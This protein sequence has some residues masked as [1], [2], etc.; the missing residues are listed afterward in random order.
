MYLAWE[1]VFSF[2]AYLMSVMCIVKDVK[3]IEHSTCF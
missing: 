1:I 2:H 3:K